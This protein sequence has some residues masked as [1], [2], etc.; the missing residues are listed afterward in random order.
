[1]NLRVLL[2]D[3][4]RDDGLRLALIATGITAALAWM[5]GC[6]GSALQSAASTQAE[7]I[8][9]ARPARV[10]WYESE[11][12]RCLAAAAPRLPGERMAHYL[13][14]MRPAEAVARTADSYRESLLA[15]Q[16]AIEIGEGGAVLP[17]LIEAARSL[18]AAAR[19]ASAPLPD[20]VESIAAII[21][22][23]LCHDAQ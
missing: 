22:E 7:V 13:A 4:W 14:C 2:A 20:E 18:L 1:M 19:A 15:A 9:R 11:H 10:E 21:P 16:A 17:C 12:E 23:G 8:V 3:A 5:T 6:S